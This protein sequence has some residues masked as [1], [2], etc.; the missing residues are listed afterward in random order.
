MDYESCNLGRFPTPVL[1]TASGRPDEEIEAY[2]SL[3][4]YAQTLYGSKSSQTLQLF[5]SKN[6][7]RRDLIFTDS[8]RYLMRLDG[9]QRSVEEYLGENLMSRLRMTQCGGV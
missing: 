2:L 3:I 7:D 1:A 4:D 5:S 6:Y 8:T 9:S